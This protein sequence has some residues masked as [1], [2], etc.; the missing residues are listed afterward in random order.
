MR[1]DE[2][3]EPYRKLV[4]QMRQDLEAFESGRMELRENTGSG[5]VNITQHWID[6]TKRRI[7]NLD[8]LIAAYEKRGQ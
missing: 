3:I 4:A 5:W 2:I 6:E 7:G 1:I 8:E